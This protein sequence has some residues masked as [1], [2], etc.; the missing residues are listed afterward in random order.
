MIGMVVLVQVVYHA[1][2]VLIAPNCGSTSLLTENTND[3][4]NNLLLN[5]S[6]A[7]DLKTSLAGGLESNWERLTSTRLNNPIPITNKIINN[8]LTNTLTA[9]FYSSITGTQTCV[10]NTTFN[11]ANS[12]N[13]Y[14]MAFGSDG[15]EVQFSSFDVHLCMFMIIMS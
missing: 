14:K 2:G 5:S 8:V 4:V 13:D 15:G 3:I 7:L 9:S 1:G 12:G 11:T 10:Y 6:T